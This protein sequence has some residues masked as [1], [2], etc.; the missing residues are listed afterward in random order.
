MPDPIAEDDADIEDTSSDDDGAAPVSLNKQPHNQGRERHKP[1]VLLVGLQRFPMLKSIQVETK[2]VALLVL[3]LMPSS[4]SLALQQRIASG[5][6]QL[7][8]VP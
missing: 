6:V 1:E 5:E 7:P 4:G 2:A 8:G 3:Q